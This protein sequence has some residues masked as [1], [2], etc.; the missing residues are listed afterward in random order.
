M[1]KGDAKKKVRFEGY[2]LARAL[3]IFGMVFINLRLVLQLMGE[4]VSGT[5]DWIANWFIGRASSIFVVLAGV[6]VALLTRRMEDDDAELSI[7]RQRLLW[8]AL[9]L[10]VIGWP[11]LIVWEGDI[12]H[13]YAAF[14]LI[15]AFAFNRSKRWLLSGAGIITILAVPVLLVWERHWDFSTMTYNGLWTINGQLMHLFLNG[16][17]PL[18]PWLAFLFLG[19]A[20][21][22]HL[23][24][25]PKSTIK[26]GL[27]ALVMAVSVELI[28]ALLLK[29]A[30]QNGINASEIKPLLGTTPMP[31]LPQYV[32][33]AG[34]CSVAVIC[35]CR[36]VGDKLKGHRVLR[37]FTYVGQMALSLYILHV[38]AFI[39]P[40]VVFTIENPGYWN[41][42][43]CVASTA[44]FCAVATAATVA[45]RH[46]LPYGPAEWL[47]RRFSDFPDRKRW[48]A[49]AGA[50][51]LMGLL[52]TGT[53]ALESSGSAASI[54]SLSSKS[55]PDEK[56]YEARCIRW[57]ND[58]FFFNSKETYEMWVKKNFG[59]KTAFEDE[60][61]TKIYFEYAKELPMG[62]VA[63]QKWLSAK[64]QSRV[65][66]RETKTST[67][68]SSLT[69]STNT[70]PRRVK[71]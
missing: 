24:S 37:P 53:H 49:L 1:N 66:A 38:F 46:F 32:L 28:S 22:R 13:Y 58:K 50:G 67:F 34:G 41:L 54:I 57:I 7:A 21:G 10:A 5:G 8:R 59:S 6:G 62:E 15:G 20:L 4:N 45:L 2:D 51:A 11:F 36:W 23:Q 40:L 16:F 3:A 33:A 9:F 65:D 12:L 30:I 17:H 19:I 61:L 29:L 42:G 31:P 26:L 18:I 63:F 69:L 64:V 48:L 43:K 71:N 25:Q 70:E 56:E 39:F 14:F 55:L 52:V 44:A 27:G 60:W 35:G 47:M 68:N